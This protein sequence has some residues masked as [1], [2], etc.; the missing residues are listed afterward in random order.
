MKR[1]KK[2]MVKNR[3]KKEGRI[4]NKKKIKIIKC[5]ENCIGEQEE[6]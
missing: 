3:E 2:E 5:L 6:E 1:G 4:L